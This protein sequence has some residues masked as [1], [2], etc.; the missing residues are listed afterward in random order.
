MNW[1]TRILTTGLALALCPAAWASSEE[2]H[3]SGALRPGQTIEIKGINGNIEAS[4]TG[5]AEVHVSAVKKGRR[6]DPSSVEIRVVPHSDGVTI[7]AVY[8][9]ADGKNECAP[10][11]GGRMNVR[12]NDVTVD[13][14]VEVPAGV[15]FTG[16]SVNGSVEAERLLGDATA[17]T[18]NGNVEVSCQ[19]VARAKTVNGSVSAYMGSANWEGDLEFETVNGSITV[20]VPANVNADVSAKT[21]NGGIDSD[22]PL[23][24]SGKWG[25]K[26]MEG[27]LGSGGPRLELKTVNGGIELRSGR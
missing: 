14:T 21:V 27:R 11:S 12:N 22:F 24:V 16:R 25:P 19:G 3:W 5:A 23:P 6:Q 10:G 13:F 7:C 4:S 2:F 20:E 17:Y 1:K 26:K 15:H 9:D 18:V 8:P